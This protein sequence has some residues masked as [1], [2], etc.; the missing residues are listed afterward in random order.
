MSVP[1]GACPHCRFIFGRHGDP[2]RCGCF[3]ALRDEDTGRVDQAVQFLAGRGHV[4]R[5]AQ[6]VSVALDGVAGEPHLHAVQRIPDTGQPRRGM[7]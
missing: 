7:R 2:T 6:P 4:E 5:G 1:S 3:T